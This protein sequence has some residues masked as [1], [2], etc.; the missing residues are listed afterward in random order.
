M[1]SYN[2]FL[3]LI[4]ASLFFG[5]V[6]SHAPGHKRHHSPVAEPPSVIPVSSPS[7][8]VPE[9]QVPTPEV[10]PALSP[11]GSPQISPSSPVI[12]PSVSP[13][14][15]PVD[16]PLTSTSPAEAPAPQSSDGLKSVSIGLVIFSAFFVAVMA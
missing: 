10:E 4:L 11:V 15:P 1:S 2:S 13:V 3:V 5:S 6:I 14:V 8:A 7:P 9:S 12:S 16:S